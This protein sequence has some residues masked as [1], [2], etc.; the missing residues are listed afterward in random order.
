MVASIVCAQEYADYGNDYA[1][2]SM[3]YD[4]ADQQITKPAS[5]GGR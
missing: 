5:M 2:D 1:Q 3:Y 4:Y